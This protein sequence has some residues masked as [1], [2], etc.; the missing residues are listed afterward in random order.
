MKIKRQFDKNEVM[1]TYLNDILDFINK[2][3][4]NQFK[5]HMSAVT[6]SFELIAASEEKILLDIYNKL[7]DS[8]HNVFIDL[9]KQILTI[10]W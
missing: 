1:L 3:V 6:F 9:N 8:G 4:L 10:K 2:T 5:K 7:I